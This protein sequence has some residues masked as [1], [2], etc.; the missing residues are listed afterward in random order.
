MMVKKLLVVLAL[1]CLV[2]IT[3]V[4]TAQA[5]PPREQHCNVNPAG[6]MTCYTTQA[7]ALSAASSGRINLA[8][9]ATAS[10]VKNS[11]DKSNVAATK[12]GTKGAV[13]PN[14]TIIQAIMWTGVG[15]T[16]SSLNFTYSSTC[17][18]G[19]IGVWND[20][21]PPWNDNFESVRLYAGC[22]GRGYDYGNVNY[23]YEGSY[24]FYYEGSYNDLG[25]FRNVMSS[26]KTC[27]TGC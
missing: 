19:G 22:Y 27:R 18:S 16:G 10:D 21:Q 3:V 8:N 25:S 13:T 24:G 15:F 7:A 12:T 26:F 20:F 6:K 5:A 11:I 17:S 1:S 9:S 14:A 23:P 4:S 2:G